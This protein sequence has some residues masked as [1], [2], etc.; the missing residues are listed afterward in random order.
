MAGADDHVPRRHPA[1]RRRDRRGH[2]RVEHERRGRPVQGGRQ[3][4]PCA[5]ADRRRRHGRPVGRGLGRLRRAAGP[6]LDDGRRDPDQRRR[7]LRGPCPRARQGPAPR[8]LRVRR[9]DGA[10]PRAAVGARRRVD[11]QRDGDHGRPRVRAR[12]RAPARQGH[13]RGDE[14]PARAGLPE[15]RRHVGE[16]VPAPRGG[17]RRRRDPP[18]R[19][20]RAAARD[21]VLRPVPAAAGA[22]RAHGGRRRRRLHHGDLDAGAGRR[23]HRAGRRARRVHHRRRH[24]PEWYERPDL[25]PARPNTGV[26]A[27]S[28]DAEGRPGPSV[29]AWVDVPG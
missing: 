10:A 4:A 1:V 24:R 26:S 11:A 9:A 18:L 6:V 17:R 19:R 22:A 29:M 14:L 15:A 28:M 12:A 23:A 27:Y 3:Q 5:P 16:A 21:G 8:A 20:P 25:P 7:R 13:L 2:P